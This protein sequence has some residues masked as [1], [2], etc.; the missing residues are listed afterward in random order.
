[1]NV[2]SYIVIT[3][4]DEVAEVMFLHVCVC[5]QGGC[6]VQGGGLLL[7]V[8]GPGG[9]GGLVSQHAL[10]QTPPRRDGYC[11]RRYASY[12]NALAFRR[13]RNCR[14]TFHYSYRTP[15]YTPLISVINIRLCQPE[16]NLYSIVNTPPKVV[17]LNEPKSHC[18]FHGTCLRQFV[19]DSTSTT[20]EPS[21]EIIIW[22][23][24]LETEMGS[25]LNL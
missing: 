4:R 7:G 23:F 24:S 21:Q 17:E 2:K 13:W 9:G 16:D 14:K 5:P 1:M 10:R 22:Y 20:P 19:P 12:W 25:M 18:M 6:L 15:Y 3:V 11:C 8:P